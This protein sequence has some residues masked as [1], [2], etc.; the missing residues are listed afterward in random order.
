MPL[1]RPF[2]AV[3]DTYAGEHRGAVRGGPSLLQGIVLCGC[4][5][6]HKMAASAFNCHF[7]GFVQPIF[8]LKSAPRPERM[9]SSQALKALAKLIKSLRQI[10]TLG[11]FMV[12][13]HTHS[14]VTVA[15]H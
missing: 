1:L 6:R 9:I 7:A 13:S 15:L 11:H 4:H 3:S 8:T 12:V 5:S 2:Y 14:L 10:C